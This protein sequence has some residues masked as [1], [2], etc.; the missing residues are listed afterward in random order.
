[1]K[2][3]EEKEKKNKQIALLTNQH[4]RR[5]PSKISHKKK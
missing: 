3:E 4:R 1:M 2:A 5:T